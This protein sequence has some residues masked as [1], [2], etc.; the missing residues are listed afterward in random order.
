M[1]QVTF[2]IRV[3]KEKPEEGAWS[4]WKKDTPPEIGPWRKDTP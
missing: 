2:K 4:P 1:K 3:K